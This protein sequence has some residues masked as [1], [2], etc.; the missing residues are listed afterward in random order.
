M[1]TNALNA[2]R[3]ASSAASTAKSHAEEYADRKLAEAIGYLADA[4]A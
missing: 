3:S 2:A 4:V 1:N